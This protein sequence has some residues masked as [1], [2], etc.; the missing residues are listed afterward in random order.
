[1][2]FET[3]YRMETVKYADII[4][5][6]GKSKRQDTYESFKKVKATA[7][8]MQAKKVEEQPENSAWGSMY[9]NRSN[10]NDMHCF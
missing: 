3:E 7:K 2:G 4:P 10:F 9:K 1:M 6:H 8:P 5:S